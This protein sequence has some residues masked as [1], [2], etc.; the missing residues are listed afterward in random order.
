MNDVTSAVTPLDP[1][2]VGA[3][4]VAGQRAGQA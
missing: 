4:D 3:A 1:E 2:L